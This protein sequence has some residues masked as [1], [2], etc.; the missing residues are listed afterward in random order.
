V[1]PEV[2]R[3]TMAAAWHLYEARTAEIAA[4]EV[5]SKPPFLPTVSW[6]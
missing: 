1:V 2:V 6:K 5:P 4:V 3:T